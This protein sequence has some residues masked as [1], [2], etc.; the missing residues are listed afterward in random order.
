MSTR[1][2]QLLLTLSLLLNTFVLGGFVYRS[3]IAPPIFERAGP[4]PPPPGQRPSPLE[5]I[6][7]ELDLDDAQKHALKA[8]FDQFATA[9]RERIREIQ[10]IREQIAAEYRKPTVDLARLDS[11]VDDLTKLRAEFQ[12]ETFHA[13]AQVE[14]QLKPEQRQRMHQVMAERLSAPFGRPPGQAGPPGSGPPP[15]RPPQ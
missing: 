8:V 11:L 4:P 7:H 1:W 5:M 9:R 10:K 13:L 6:T 2:L 14:G 3:W 12:K 15:G